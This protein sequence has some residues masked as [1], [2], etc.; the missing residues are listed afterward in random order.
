MKD[1]SI[2]LTLR[3]AAKVERDELVRFNLKLIA[4]ELADALKANADDPTPANMIKLNGKWAQG[5]RMLDFAGRRNGAPT[6][7]GAGLKEGA[8]LQVAA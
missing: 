1:T 3:D 5:M 8:L 2:L 4:D 7:N 6:G